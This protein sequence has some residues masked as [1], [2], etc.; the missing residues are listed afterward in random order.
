[1]AFQ[2]I[3]IDEKWLLKPKLYLIAIN[4]KPS[5]AQL[6]KNSLKRLYSIDQKFHADDK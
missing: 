2:L 1:L 4:W 3:G 5:K 6:G